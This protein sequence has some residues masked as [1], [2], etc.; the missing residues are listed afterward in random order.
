MGLV[1]VGASSWKAGTMTDPRLAVISKSVNR[2]RER[3]HEDPDTGCW[4][5]P[6]AKDAQGEGQVTFTPPGGKQANLPAH[7]AFWLA[8]VGPVPPGKVLRPTCRRSD[9]VNPEHREALTRAECAL[10]GSSPF[11]VNARR[12]E[13][14]NGHLLVGDDALV[15]IDPSGRRRCVLC[16][17]EITRRG[18]AKARQA[19]TAKT[20]SQPKAGK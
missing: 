9:C 12:T 2:W 3:I 8:M 20:T 11:A 16:S 4:L 7:R 5:W 14:K 19:Q 13:C 10:K 1:A 18:R 15:H 17:R 6:G